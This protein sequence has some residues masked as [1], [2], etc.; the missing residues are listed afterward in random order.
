MSRKQTQAELQAYLNSPYI[1]PTQPD[2]QSTQQ[3]D[4]TPHTHLFTDLNW[5]TEC[6]PPL[7]A[8]P[9]YPQLYHLLTVTQQTLIGYYPHD[10][11]ELTQPNPHYIAWAP[12][13]ETPLLWS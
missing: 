5:Q 13:S 9:N 7:P 8:N 12:L 10:T 11:H 6:E 4:H 1:P 2:P 3:P